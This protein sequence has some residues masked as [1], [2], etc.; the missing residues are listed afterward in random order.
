M[1]GGQ[2]GIGESDIPVTAGADKIYHMKAK[3]MTAVNLSV[4]NGP[5]TMRFGRVDTK[6]SST[7]WASYNAIVDTFNQVGTLYQVPQLTALA[8]GLS[9]QKARKASFTSLG[10]GVDWQNL[11]LQ[12][13][14]GKTKSYVA[15]SD[16]WYVMGGYRLG[17]F[18]PYY[19]YSKLKAQGTVVNTIP[20]VPAL[21]ALSRIIDTLG[22]PV[23]QT[24]NTIGV[25][26]DFHSS[27]AFKLQLDRIK[28]EN[29][30]GKLLNAAP[31]FKGPVTVGAV[32]LD[33]VF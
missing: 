29:G 13:E 8:D 5:I 25:R 19:T 2:F 4:E 16:A 33:F 18:L 21:A 10:L 26:W 6:L 17:A 22:T 32:A 20:A 15:K 23:V 27:M 1:L 24:T 11:V 9:I 28:P 7:D 14:Y 31:G 3:S 12:S 30:A